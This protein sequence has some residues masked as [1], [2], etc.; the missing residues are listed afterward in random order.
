MLLSRLAMLIILIM[1]IM[2]IILIM[3]SR[4]SGAIEYVSNVYICVHVHIHDMKCDLCVLRWCACT[5]TYD[6]RLHICIHTYEASS[7]TSGH[8]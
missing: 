3:L 2:L 1:L 5:H 7:C 4:E 8:S 6:L